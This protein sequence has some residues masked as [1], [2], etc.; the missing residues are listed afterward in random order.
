MKEKENLSD[1]GKTENVRQAVERRTA[2]GMIRVDMEYP[3]PCVPQPGITEEKD[4]GLLIIT[5]S[6]VFRIK[7]GETE[8][9]EELLHRISEIMM[10]RYEK[11][12]GEYIANL[13]KGE[14]AKET[15]IQKKR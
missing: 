4:G 13:K 7:N 11:Q 3:Y 9:Q 6:H 5:A 12:I 1:S 15:K 8:M 2:L 10:K 14:K